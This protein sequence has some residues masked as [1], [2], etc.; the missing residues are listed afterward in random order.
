M[1][2]AVSAD[3]IWAGWVYSSGIIE[4]TPPLPDGAACTVAT[5]AGETWW[6]V[7]GIVEA[8]A[9]YY[10]VK[11]SGPNW[12]HAPDGHSFLQFGAGSPQ[13]VNWGDFNPTHAYTANVIGNGEPLQFRIYDWYDAD[14]SNNYCHIPVT[15]SCEYLGCTYTPGYW[16]THSSYGPA[17]KADDAWNTL[18]YGPDTDFFASGMSW[19]E[20]F[21]TKPTGGNAYIILAHPYM[22]AYLNGA[23]NAFVPTEVQ[24]AMADARAI[25]AA[26]SNSIPKD[27]PDRAIAI[28]L[29]GILDD[30]NN[31]KLGVPHC[32]DEIIV[33]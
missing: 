23:N 8:D 32:G 26:H 15:V 5:A 2:P 11:D 30:Y 13:D 17:P 10:H 3:Q 9:Q 19:Y 33:E 20:T 22:A 24:V 21:L 14:A 12:I 1:I 31:G 27:D 29:A 28:S 4:T 25:L 6:P 7:D 16:K 18:D